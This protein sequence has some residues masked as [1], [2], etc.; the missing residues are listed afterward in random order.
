MI[1]RQNPASGFV[2]SKRKNSLGFRTVWAG[3]NVVML[4]TSEEARH[5]SGWGGVARPSGLGEAK[6]KEPGKS[7]RGPVT[8]R[9][10]FLK[11]ATRAAVLVPPVMLL[12]SRPS[13][14]DMFSS[15]GPEG[16]S[17][18][19]YGVNRNEAAERRVDT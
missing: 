13:T 4:F 7:Q 1:T 10:H 3:Y 5:Q 6:M 2:H 19:D 11:K 17:P 16:A 12:L 8:A 14:A 15:M 18:H 9:R